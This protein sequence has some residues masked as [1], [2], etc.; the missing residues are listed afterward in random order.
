[1]RNGAGR[2]NRTLM[3]S[4][5][6]W[7]FTTKLYPQKQCNSDIEHLAWQ[8]ESKKFK[9]FFSTPLILSLLSEAP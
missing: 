8:A 1:M 9:I 3:I 6:G 2:G 7:S 4:L 5:E